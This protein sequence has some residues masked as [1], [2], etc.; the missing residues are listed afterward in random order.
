MIRIQCICQCCYQEDGCPLCAKWHCRV[1]VA[2]VPCSCPWH[3]SYLSKWEKV[4][5]FFLC[6]IGVLRL[7]EPQVQVLI[8]SLWNHSL[9]ELL[10]HS[11]FQPDYPKKVIC[12]LCREIV[13]VESDA[14]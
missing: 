2:A 5:G 11:E 1:E 12:L 7:A 3:G 6:I 8:S 4:L 13:M 10:H 9:C 14:I